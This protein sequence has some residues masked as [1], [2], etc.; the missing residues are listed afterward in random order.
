MAPTR[1]FLYR[2]SLIWIPVGLRK[3]NQIEVSLT[4]FLSQHA[5]D[6]TPA[7]VVG[8]TQ[9]GRTVLTD[10]GE[11]RNDALIIATG[12]AFLP[13]A[14]GTEH[15]LQLCPGVHAAEEVR[16]KLAAMPG[17]PIAIGCG[18]NPAEPGAS[19]CGPMLELA[20]G[21]DTLLRTR[22]QRERFV[23]TFF[24]TAP[25]P[26]DRFGGSAATRIGAE[27]DQRDIQMQTATVLREFSVAGVH[28][29]AGLIP[30]ELSVFTPGLTGPGWLD[31][32]D[33]PR[34]AG[35]FVAG[36]EHCAVPGFERVFVAGDV[37]S[38]PGPAWSPKLAHMA[39]LQ[40]NV[41]AAN[42]HAVLCGEAPMQRLH[43]ELVCAIDTLDGGIPVFRN[44]AHAFSLPPVVP[45]HWAKRAVERRFLSGLR[46]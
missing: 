16:T 8:L 44:D 9:G 30:S 42:L 15:A 27:L 32:S 25:Q 26:L 40:A 39:Q 12:A 4:D 35:G 45:V 37:G 14:V 41:A 38:F 22:G 13:D 3:P 20:F 43:H 23:L 28:T 46:R 21:I 6:F 11:V 31:G 7:S 5:I 36:D 34:S 19:R 1:K 33:L 10:K 17:G 2:P 24:S 29:E 18:E